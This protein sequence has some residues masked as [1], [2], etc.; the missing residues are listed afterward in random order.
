MWNNLESFKT[1]IAASRSSARKVVACGALSFLLTSHALTSNGDEPKVKVT[2][3]SFKCITEMTKVRH[4]YVDN[5]LGNLAGTVAVANAGTGDYPEGSV[6]QL[7][8]NEVM[9]KQQ[10]GFSPTTRD[11]EF[12]W[13]DVDKN[14]SKIYTRGFAEVNNR[15]GLNCFTCH[16]K[17]KPEF[18]FICETEHGCDPIPVTKAM[19]GALQRTDPRCQGSDQVSAED[20]E[21][22]R[23]LGELIKAL[24]QNKQ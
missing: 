10:K 1:A 20:T 2:D 19:F 3:E 11:W 7:M 15:F 13:I 21:A 5:L 12:F 24:T 9:V 4:F 8:P 16:V 22:L 17:A 14:G 18:D 6:V 23:E